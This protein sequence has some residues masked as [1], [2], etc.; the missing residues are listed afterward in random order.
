MPA[1]SRSKRCIG[2]AATLAVLIAAQ[3]IGQQTPA[4]EK[5]FSPDK[6]YQFGDIDSINTFNG[7]LTARIPLGPSYPINGGMSYK[8]GLTYNSKIWD[9]EEVPACTLCP[10]PAGATAIMTIPSRRSNA[11]LGWLLSFG[12]IITKANST[13]TGLYDVYESPDGAD[14]VNQG[15]S[16]DGTYIRRTNPGNGTTVL[17]FPDGTMKTFDSASGD[18]LNA[19]DRFGNG[20]DVATLTSPVGTPCLSTNF[21]HA[22]RITDTSSARTNYVCFTNRYSYPQNISAGIVERVVLVAPPDEH[23]TAQQAIYQFLY[24]DTPKVCRGPGNTLLTASLDVQVPL[25]TTITQ[26]DGTRYDLGYSQPYTYPPM[27][28]DGELASI[29]LPTGATITYGYGGSAIPVDKCNSSPAWNSWVIGVATRTISGPK[30]PPNTTWHYTSSLS[31]T[32]AQISCLNNQ[33][34]PVFKRAPA[35]QMIV[36]VTDPLGNVNENYYSVWPVLD[37]ERIFDMSGQIITANGGNIVGS[38]NGFRRVEYGFPMT[39]LANSDGRPLSQRVYSAAGYA[40]S[41]RTPLRSFYRTYEHDAVACSDDQTPSQVASCANSN[42]RVRQERT[43]YEDDNGKIADVDSSDFDGLGHYRTVTLGGN[44]AQ[45]NATIVTA[46]NKHDPDVNPSTGINSGTYPGSFTFPAATD[47]WLIGMPW[48]ITRTEAGSTSKEEMCFSPLTGFLRARRIRTTTTARSSSDLL[49]LYEHDALGNVTSE[50]SFGGDVKNNAPD[51]NLCAIA[52]TPPTDFEYKMSH[53]YTNGVRAT[54]QYSGVTFLSLNRTID[55]PTGFVSKAKDTADQETKFSYDSA[56]R[57]TKVEQPGLA[58]TNYSYSIAS[59]SGNSFV[60]ARVEVK[61]ISAATGVTSGTIEKHYQYDALG[62]LWREKTR[63]P[64][65]SFS[66]RETLYNA[67]GWTASVSEQEKLVIPGG[68]TEFDFTPTNKTLYSGYDPFG[69]PGSVTLPD[70]HV[71][72]FSYLGV[73][74]MVRTTKI[75]TSTT[76]ET[77]VPVTETYDRQGRLCQL[78]ENSNP[79]G[80]A[81]V[82]TYGY[83]VTGALARVCMNATIMGTCGQ[84]RKFSYDNRGFL[85]SETHPENGTTTYGSYDA[86]GHVI[87]R[88][89]ALRMTRPSVYTRLPTR[90]EERSSSSSTEWRTTLR[91]ASPISETASSSARCAATT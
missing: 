82:T 69:R 30:I 18:F 59:G 80:S 45:G 29:G 39:H 5:G 88:L 41:P 38:P 44:F 17:E 55:T 73:Q 53:T 43:V 31:T 34:I 54:S 46:Y 25:L 78:T 76:G 23:G 33:Q 58:P 90:Q 62:R 7:N 70:N 91:M 36:T 6:L 57:L 48:S 79:D 26:P 14:H 86:H 87:T 21:A 52:D 20:F 42:S 24:S 13:N 15:V 3:A 56:F 1:L 64:D 89:N 22:W 50:S 4:L 63:M 74:S 85:T 27:C 77:D 49:T 8:L 75:A 10:L 72:A 66:L 51:N 32:D 47:P 28:R 40:A 2:F 37:S 65:D 11:G 71:T 81:V 35:E 67:N 12:R 9:Y 19:R 61:T 60:P 68:G 83:G 16:Q 84:E